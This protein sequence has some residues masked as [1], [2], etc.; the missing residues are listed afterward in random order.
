MAPLT[1][2][3][4]FTHLSPA[5]AQ[6]GTAAARPRVIGILCIVLLTGLGWLYLGLMIGGSV[7]RGGDLLG[8]VQALCRPLGDRG[9][10]MPLAGSWSAPDVALLWAMWAAMSLAMMLPS[11]APMILTYAEIAE[12]AARKHEPVVSPVAL[13][14]GYAA[15]WLGFA[16]LATALQIA[17][18]KIALVDA[19][20][21]P[22]SRILS[23]ALFVVAGLYQFSSLKQAC[24]KACQRPFPFF[25]ANWQTRTR[26]VFKLGLQQGV[27][28]LGC[29]WAMMLLMFAIGVMNILWM[30]ALAIVMTIEKMTAT[31]RFSHAI[32]A[33]LIAIGVG[34]YAFEALAAMKWL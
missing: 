12:T 18:T 33:V 7:S 8:L 30:A 4:A 32:G 21:A 28:C 3:R 14:A 6:L 5:A 31:R 27:H 26:G 20:M 25:F 34:M 2:Q 19:A 11:A 24:L 9:F 29:C 23:A 10:G 13:A 17:L 16:V 22:A 1:D 15:I